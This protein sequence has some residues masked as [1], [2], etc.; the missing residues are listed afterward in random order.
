MTIP[1]FHHILFKNTQNNPFKNLP[2]PPLQ[3]CLLPFSKHFHN[4]VN[5]L[6]AK[7]SLTQNGKSIIMESFIFYKRTTIKIF[8][9]AIHIIKCRKI[10]GGW[11]RESDWLDELNGK[12]CNIFHH[13]L[14]VFCC[15]F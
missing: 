3:K 12:F 2:P 8:L 4:R 9:V 7:K 1:A 14:C 13:R 11:R 6:I 5:L 10:L 15:W